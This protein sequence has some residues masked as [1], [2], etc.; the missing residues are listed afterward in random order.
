MMPPPTLT[1]LYNRVMPLR[2][3]AL[4][5]RA[6]AGN[7]QPTFSD[8]V[9]NWRSPN[10]TLS[11]L[12]LIGGDIVQRAV[13]QLAG[14]GPGPLCPVAFSFGWLAYSV[15]ALTSAVGDGRLLPQ[16][17]CPGY[18]VNAKS[19]Y[20]RE[21][22]SWV[23]GRL[24]RDSDSARKFKSTSLTIA[25]YRTVQ[26]NPCNMADAAS[27]SKARRTGMPSRDWVYWSGVLV[28]LLQHAIAVIPGALHGNWIVLIVTVGGTALALTC[29]GLRQWRDEKFAARRVDP[30]KGREVV[31]LTRGNGSSFAMVVVSERAGLRIEDLATGRG[32]RRRETNVMTGALFVC[33]L[34]LLLTVEG[35]QNDA[36]YLLAVGGL[37]MVQNA[38]AAGATRS[39][40][41]LGF[42]FEPLQEE[43]EIKEKKVM[44]TLMRAEERE[45][46]VGLALL[47]IFF[48]GELWPE[49]QEYW[50]ARKREKLEEDAQ[51][52][53]RARLTEKQL[54]DEKAAREAALEHEKNTAAV[55]VAV[56]DDEKTRPSDV[57][58]ISV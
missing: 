49:E 5:A 51:K 10:D 56:A 53:T 29:G 8:Q 44:R 22:A 14:T 36:W 39:A 33:W 58:A 46:G 17:D 34:V 12:M 42:H 18:V 52:R 41:A 7:V 27:A 19:G 2:G 21:N 23:L 25:F 37:G 50:D 38:V 32:K 55:Q 30:C 9:S 15:S 3:N 45:R 40:D 4:S 26:D 1:K 28:I 6:G 31:A 35:L 54:A 16:P 24:L 47:P 48:P 20:V 57:T 13:A 43:D 11:L